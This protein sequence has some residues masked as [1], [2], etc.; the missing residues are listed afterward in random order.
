MIDLLTSD[1]AIVIFS[2]AG[3]LVTAVSIFRDT[4]FR[5]TRGESEW[6]R[7]GQVAAFTER[8]EIAA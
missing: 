4:R 1:P 5:E 7:T 8:T 6:I 3:L 2:C